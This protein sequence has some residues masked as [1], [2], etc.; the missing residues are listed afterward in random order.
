MIYEGLNLDEERALY[1]ISDATVRACNFR[2]AADGESALKETKGLRIID[3]GFDLRYPM[4]HMR[5]S[6]VTDCNLSETC[7][8]PLWYC[9]KID[10]TDTVIDGVKALRECRQVSM[11]DCVARSTEFGWFCEDISLTGCVVKSEYPFL[12]TKGLHLND[13]RLS[14]KYSFQ[15]VENATV[16]NSVLDTKDAFWHSK[17]VTVTDSVVKG[18]YLGWY[19][20]GLTLIRCKIEGTQ[21]LCYCKGLTLIDC[22]TSGCDLAFERSEVKASVTGAIESV[23]NPIKG[24]VL[25][26]SIGQIIFDIPSDCTVTER[27]K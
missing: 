21:P 14:G 19:S 20:E 13:V 4:W 6:S 23:K 8:A 5:A 18:E 15:Y 9:D 17:N 2:G 27:N 7:R 16:E 11:T 10:M 1:G 22:E 3:C 24:H 26:D 25:A 12:R